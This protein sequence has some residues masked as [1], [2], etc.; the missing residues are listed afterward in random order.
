MKTLEILLLHTWGYLFSEENDKP[1]GIE[2][3][4][5]RHLMLIQKQ[6]NKYVLLEIWTK[7]K[8]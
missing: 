7:Q 1:T 8:I 6:C 2:L 3:I 5:N 4:N